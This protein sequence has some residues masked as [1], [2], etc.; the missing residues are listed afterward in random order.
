MVPPPYL[1]N[2]IMF[3]K[4]TMFYQYRY[5]V[6]SVISSTSSLTPHPLPYLYFLAFVCIYIVQLRLSSVLDQ[7]FIMNERTMLHIFRFLNTEVS[8]VCHMTLDA[9]F[10]SACSN[11]FTESR[12]KKASLDFFISLTLCS[13]HQHIIR[14][15]LSCSQTNL[16]IARKSVNAYIKV[17][18]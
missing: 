10:Q 2:I 12:S 14:V 6:F 4:S 7:Y 5:I 17:K 15:Q 3:Q 18:L 1:T 16:N 11:N 13:H 9:Y 8:N